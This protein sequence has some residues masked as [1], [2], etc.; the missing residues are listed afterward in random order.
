MDIPSFAEITE[1]NLFATALNAIFALLGSNLITALAG[2]FA[3]AYGAHRIAEY[4]KA[5]ES[6]L[7]EIRSVNAAIMLSASIH[8]G[9]LNFKEKLIKPVK[10]QYENDRALFI[11]ITA[12]RAEQVENAQAPLMIT[13]DFRFFE[14]I[15]LPTDI[16]QEVNF[17]KIS[18]NGRPLSLTTVL[19]QT[20][21][22]INAMILS[23]NEL[24]QHFKDNGPWPSHV[25][26]PLYFGVP[27]E[28]GNIDE[29][30][31]SAVRAIS[32]K[33]D[34]GIF[35]S[36]LLCED[37]IQ[38]G[39]NVRAKFGKGAPA[40]N[41]V[42]FSLAKRKGLLPDPDSYQSWYT[43]FGKPVP[44]KDEAPASVQTSNV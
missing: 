29:R 43:G 12:Q 31:F 6:T 42:D 23:R 18:L 30:Y 16:L 32:E 2:A 1:Y 4:T 24:C 8:T 9:F 13:T 7:N 21:I 10:D 26:A 11:E 39:E 28:H 35:F 14:Q 34:D 5:K 44:P 41:K 3:G 27:D 37:L 19:T 17:Q 36:G 20:S 40:I 25:L 33:V 15:S 38:H 22:S